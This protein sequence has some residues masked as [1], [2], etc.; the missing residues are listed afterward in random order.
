MVCGVC[1]YSVMISIY[2]S[3]DFIICHVLVANN[4]M[5]MICCRDEPILHF[6]LLIFLSGNSF[7]PGALAAGRC[8]P[9]FLEL[10]LSTNICVCVPAPEAINN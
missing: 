6:V 4:A 2:M 8:A 3:T 9:G 5:S 1:E 7:K 10:L